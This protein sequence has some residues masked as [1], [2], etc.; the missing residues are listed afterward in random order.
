MSDL[1]DYIRY[2]GTTDPV[3]L[4]EYARLDPEYRAARAIMQARVE[5]GLTQEELA[6]RTGMKASNIS[7]LETGRSMPTL[8]TLNQLA[9]GLGKR[10]DIRF[11]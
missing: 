2:R 6:K 10:L 3:F 11:V 1:H 5:A 9:A 8:R 7:R 4:E